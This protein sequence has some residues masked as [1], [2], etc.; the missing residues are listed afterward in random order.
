ML[1]DVAYYMQPSLSGHT[2]LQGRFVA[3]CYL[4]NAAQRLQYSSAVLFNY[5]DEEK[6][7]IKEKMSHLND[8]REAP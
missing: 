3:L 8:A 2:L 4:L 5:R 1:C 7:L 6:F